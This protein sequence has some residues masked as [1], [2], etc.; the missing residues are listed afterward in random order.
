MTRKELMLVW[1]MALPFLNAPLLNDNLF[2]ITG[3]KPVNLLAALGSLVLLSGQ[4]TF[5]IRDR[6]EWLSLLALSIYAGFFTLAIVRSLD[7]V[8]IFHAELPED[9]G[10][11]IS[12]YLLSYYVRPLFELVPFIFILKEMRSPSDLESGLKAIGASIFVLSCAF[13]FIVLFVN[14]FALGADRMLM[15]AT[16]GQYF[17]QHYNDMACTY[18]TSAPILAFLAI[19][20]GGIWVFNLLLAA[21]VILLLQSRTGL[22]TFGVA[23]GIVFLIF[24]RSEY[25]VIGAVSVVVAALAKAAPTLLTLASEGIHGSHFTI[26][27][28]LTDRESSMWIPL[29]GEWVSDNNLLLF[30]AGRFGILTSPMWHLGLIFQAAHAHN[31]FID[32]FLDSGLILLIVLVVT[33]IVLFT[34]AWRIGRKL[35][36]RLYWCLLVCPF[37]YLMGA[38]TGECFYPSYMNM[39]MFPIVALII[40]VARY[41][42]AASQMTPLPN[43]DRSTRE[44]ML[45]VQPAHVVS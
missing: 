28:L 29:V 6:I 38:L 31:A 22:L 4:G 11:N 40:N 23:V 44:S 2:G 3:F 16:T 13:M 7:N 18:F 15:S 33:I 12:N 42:L 43:S 30:G 45:S 17:G 10:A 5:R 35:N 27:S 34:I 14:P 8:S 39:L 9:Y 24:R 20:R 37:A 21:L 19:R 41:G 25:L 32:F 1:L 26:D 36:N